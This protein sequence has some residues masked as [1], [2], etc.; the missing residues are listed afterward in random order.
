MPSGIFEYSDHLILDV[1]FSFAN[2]ELPRYS[3]GN[4]TDADLGDPVMDVILDCGDVLYLP[5]GYIHQAT[6]VEDCHSL[7]ITI[8]AF[9]R[10]AWIDLLEKVII[11]VYCE[12]FLDCLIR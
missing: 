9:Q 1:Y 3:S 10:N 2:E 4:F 6:T 11:L 5:R 12:K 7:H 8:S